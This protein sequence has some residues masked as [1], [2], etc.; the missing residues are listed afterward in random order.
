[1]PGNTFKPPRARVREK[2]FSLDAS[3]KRNREVTWYRSSTEYSVKNWE[4]PIVQKGK[5]GGMWGGLVIC[6]PAKG[7]VRG[8]SEARG[9]VPFFV[10]QHPTNR[11]TTLKII[12]FFRGF[13]LTGSK[14]GLEEPLKT[15]KDGF[16]KSKMTFVGGQGAS[17]GR[18]R[19]R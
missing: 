3:E 4:K 12:V 1:V 8:V 15:M 16:R 11:E 14:N 9:N 13:A 5:G 17:G 6:A 19:R 18:A 2:M 7:K 10:N